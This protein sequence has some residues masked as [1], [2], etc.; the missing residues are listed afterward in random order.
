MFGILWR[1]RWVLAV[2]GLVTAAA[3]FTA[4][5]RDGTSL[6]TRETL[7][8]AAIATAFVTT[9]LLFFL[10]AAYFLL[11]E[12]RAQNARAR[13]DREAVRNELRAHGERSKAQIAAVEELIASTSTALEKQIE[14]KSNALE[15]K[16]NA[17]A[18]NASSVL[19]EVGKIKSALDDDG[20]LG[21]I[22]NELEDLKK[23]LSGLTEAL[24]K[25]VQE[26][27][28]RL[29]AIEAEVPQQIGPVK[30][31]IAE[32]AKGTEAL[33]AKSDDLSDRLDKLTASDKETAV[34]SA[35][36][37]TKLS[38]VA[39]HIKEL[40][41]GAAT[42][43]KRLNDLDRFTKKTAKDHHALMRRL[44]GSAPP[45]QI[46]TDTDKSAAAEIVASGLRV[47]KTYAPSEQRSGSSD[48]ETIPA[49]PF[50]FAEGID[51]DRND[52]PLVSVII[53]L[54]NE[55]NFVSDTIECLKRQTSQNFEAIIVDDASTDASMAEAI[56]AIDNDPRFVTARHAANGGLSAARNTGIRL[57]K[58]PFVTFL[59]SD[60]FLL[61]DALS[62]SVAA[63]LRLSMEPRARA[64]A[65]VYCRLVT[66][67]QNISI[68]EA[69][70]RL[71]QR[72]Y[73]MA[74]VDFVTSDGECPF[75]AHAPML[76]TDIVRAHGGFDESYKYGCEDWDLWQ[77]IMR[78]GYA[79]AP[80]GRLAG[81]YRRKR[82]SMVKSTPKEHL[83]TAKLLFERARTPIDPSQIVD[84]AP[85]VFEEGINAYA[86][87]QR[88]IQRTSQYAAINAFAGDTAFASTLAS[89]PANAAAYTEVSK[90]VRPYIEAALRRTT[91]VDDGTLEE[92]AD[93][94]ELFTTTLV[95]AIED[96]I[97]IT[98]APA[99]AEQPAFDV[100]F[101]PQTGAQAACF[102]AIATSLHEQGKSVAF[103][104]S[105]TETG[106]QGQRRF[107][108]DQNFQTMSL[109]QAVMAG[110]EARAFVLMRPYTAVI[111]DCTP[112]DA[113][114]VEVISPYGEISDPDEN[115]PRPATAVT[116]LTDAALV[117][118]S[119]IDDQDPSPLLDPGGQPSSVFE[120]AP[121]I[122]SR[123][124]SFYQTPDH[125]AIVQ[126]KDKWRGERCVIIGNGP[127][128]NE[129]DLTLLQGE[130]T[131]AVNGIFYKREDMGF[132]PTFYVVE[133][134]SVMKE[135]LDAIK[136]YSATYK[137]FPTIYRKLHD[138]TETTAFFMMNRGFYEEASPSFCVPRFSE[139]AAR[140]VFCGQSVTHINLQLAYYF[141]FYE[142][143]L[144]GM[145]F[146]YVIPESAKQKGDIITSTED[147]PN[148]FHP[149]YFGKGKTW[150][151]PKLHRVKLNYELARDIYAADGR[152]I[153]N[154]TKGGALDVFDRVD[155]EA[156]F[157]PGRKTA[158]TG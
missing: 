64:Y 132:D 135:N 97:A 138:Q 86:D 83:D 77:R 111:R 76:L 99:V 60:D 96:R 43:T 61:P 36:V 27:T 120:P 1:A 30:D 134:S 34:V 130:Y 108:A 103:I 105:E 78:N 106:D 128:L 87:K 32:F 24:D 41:A 72:S 3:M 114:I 13:N 84:G 116:D 118:T 148:H 4:A 73:A 153:L 26:I 123:D 42:Q 152:K 66:M 146:S 155:F 85:F 107:L 62:S 58:A 75:N 52:R 37:S 142:V 92:I 25:Q 129:L 136:D 140:R 126:L 44:E 16:S 31:Q 57:A 53:P 81:I 102:A 74:E 131:F 151:D 6:A 51:F 119:L 18:Q 15:A 145:D 65:G 122:I 127:S 113:A 45:A 137:L 88:F 124:E 80:T 38:D 82:G 5:G 95:K 29:G 12:Y 19:S 98:A 143:Y 59:D 63:A 115:L 110:M 8:L 150:K 14:T 121:L 141:G 112:A 70:A 104:T 28:A 79:F 117:L 71:K 10:H 69:L 39:K 47:I 94:V 11:R 20:G 144:I 2:F 67:P 17:V 56:A 109:N 21:K 40:S 46:D 139:D 154:A 48:D 23:Q 156:V 55:E 93:D 49:K 157:G 101:L 22:P 68:D 50:R 91:A 54:Y 7:Q 90:T 33:S 9:F 149:A 125:D 100:A 133:D 89:F 158:E 147:D 35:A